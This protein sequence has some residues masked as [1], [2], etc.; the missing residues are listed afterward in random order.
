MK[1]P[2]L[3]LSS[4]S[5]VLF[6]QISGAQDDPRAAIAPGNPNLH[7]RSGLGHLKQ[8]LEMDRK[9]HVAFLGGSITQNTGGH[10]AMV[11]AWLKQKFP[12]VKVT[13]TN[14]GLGSTCSTSG[15]FRLEPHIFGKGEVDLLVVEFAVNDDQDAGHAR[16]ECIRGMEGIISQVQRKHPK[17]GIVMVHFVN[18]GMLDKL[19]KGEAPVAIAAHEAVAA[20]HGVISVNVAAEVAAATKGG[21]YRWKD[22]GGT[23]PGRVGSRIASHMITAAIEAGLA[24]G[25]QEPRRKLADLLD[26]GSYGHGRFFAPMDPGFA[27][28]GRRGKVGRELLPLG[29]IRSQYSSYQ[30]LRGEQPGAR[31]I[32]EF[33]GRTVGAFLLAGP[34]AGI[35]EA[36][37][38]GGPATRHDLYHRYSRGLNYPRSVIFGT[39]LKPGKHVLALQ[40]VKEKNPGS[41]GT[42]ASILFFEVNR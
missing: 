28:G 21:R 3:L 13:V 42:T 27:A 23:H 5:L 17:C 14:A 26:A 6:P 31:L 37:I 4:W 16:R 9:C 33:T 22:Y 19:G 20:R 35:L 18:P 7:V 12:G 29:G 1:A 32:I 39:D 11:P 8:R 30:L 15:A 10:T 25:N 34:D 36:S 40:L 41:K 2:L 24:K 38:D